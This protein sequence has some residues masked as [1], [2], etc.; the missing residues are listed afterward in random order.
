M[1]NIYK[2]INTQGRTTKIFEYQNGTYE[3]TTEN[4]HTFSI[5][6]CDKEEHIAHA[7]RRGHTVLLNNKQL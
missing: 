5:N 6:K 4:S 1:K 2:T 7:L 3:M